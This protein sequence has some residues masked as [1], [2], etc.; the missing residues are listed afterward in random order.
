VSLGQVGFE[1]SDA[2]ARSLP[3][4]LG[5]RYRTLQYHVS[6]HDHHFHHDDNILNL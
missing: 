1:V 6:L 3:A 5:S 2:Q 4:A